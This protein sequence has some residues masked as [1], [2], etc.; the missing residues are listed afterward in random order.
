MVDV[1]DGSVV[2]LTCNHVVTLSDDYWTLPTCEII[3]PS[4]YLGGK[5]TDGI[6]KVKRLLPLRVSSTPVDVPLNR[7][8]AAIVRLSS[9]ADFSPAHRGG[10]GEYVYKM[11]SPRIGE[12]VNMYGA[13]T[14]EWRTG[15]VATVDH[16]AK[17]QYGTDDKPLYARVGPCCTVDPYITTRPFGQG[18][19]SGSI[20][21]VPGPIEEEQAVVGLFIGGKAEGGVGIITDITTVAAELNLAPLSMMPDTRLWYRLKGRNQ[22]SDPW[23]Y[24]GADS[25]LW[26]RA[27]GRGPSDGMEFCFLPYGEGSKYVIVSN[28]IPNVWTVEKDAFGV[29]AWGRLGIRS[30]SGPDR[31]TFRL[32]SELLDGRHHVRIY[33]PTTG[34]VEMMGVEPGRG[35]IR[36]STADDASQHFTFEPSRSV[37]HEER[38]ELDK[39]LT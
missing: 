29:K 3:Q 26:L 4:S 23:R 38:R 2:L 5:A 16:E 7:A 33:E 15:R 25:A 22:F 11:R 24:I 13:S 6:G 21:C 18:G 37:T 8:D 10:G 1:T 19:D 12:L 14:R 30:S 20:V 31:S 35:I 27:D 28:D 17:M 9:P 36:W 32:Q 39:I 34:Y